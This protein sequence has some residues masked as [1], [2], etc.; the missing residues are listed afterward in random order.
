LGSGAYYT[1]LFRTG[2]WLEQTPPAGRQVEDFK[3][4]IRMMYSFRF[5][6]DT[7]IA[8]TGRQSG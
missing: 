2:H 8:V 5:S 4:K 1:V 3:D 6:L 7:H